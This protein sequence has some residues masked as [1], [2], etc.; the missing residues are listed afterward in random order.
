MTRIDKL[1]HSRPA[2]SDMYA[3]SCMNIWNKYIILTQSYASM[4]VLTF[5]PTPNYSIMK[6]ICVLLWL[7]VHVCNVELCDFSE[8]FSSCS[9]LMPPSSVGGFYAG[10]RPATTEYPNT[11]KTCR[12]GGREGGCTSTSHIKLERTDTR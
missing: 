1:E 8:L 2:E 7:S 9:H 3:Q 4:C 11:T 10:R 5:V 6:R 12:R